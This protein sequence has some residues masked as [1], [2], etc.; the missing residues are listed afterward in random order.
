MMGLKVMPP[1]AATGVFLHGVSMVQVSNGPV[2]PRYWKYPQHIAAPASVTPQLPENDVVTAA[3]LY[4]PLTGT[5]TAANVSAPLPRRP[6]VPA[7][8]HIAV[9]PVVI[10][11][12]P[13]TIPSSKDA[14][15]E[16]GRIGTGKIGRASCRERW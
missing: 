13:P 9:C 6:H 16:S 11:Q 8:Q 5:G 10:A 1:A 15:L 12:A 2:I 7:A 14:K 3:N 4:P